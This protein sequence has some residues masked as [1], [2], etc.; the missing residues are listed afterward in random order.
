MPGLLKMVH[1]IDEIL[2]SENDKMMLKDLRNQ[3]VILIGNHP[4]TKEPPIAF[5]VSQMMYSRFHYMAGREVFDWGNGMVGK[6]IQSAG[7]YSVLAGISDRESLKVS[8]E[9][10]AKKGG[11][12]ALFPEGEPTGGENDNLLPFQAGAAQL[13][14]WGY[15]DAKKKDAD[16]EVYILP[17]FVKYRMSGPLIDIRR[18]VDRSLDIMERH[19]RITKTGKTIVHRLLSIGKQMVLAAEKEFG[20]EPQEEWDFDY[21]VGRLRHT[22]LDMVAERAAIDKWN[23]EANSIEKL[24]KL[25]SVFEMVSIGM[26]DPKLNLPDKET[27]FWG[28]E[29]CQRAYDFISIHTEYIKS[30]PTPERIYEWIYRFENEALG[31][32]R[33]RRQR[34]YVRFT[35]PYKMSEIYPEYKKKKRVI[36]EKLT[37][38]LRN[39]IQGLLDKEKALSYLLFEEDYTF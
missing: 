10:I 2:V 5:Q 3:R 28:R 36:L 20:I 17:M 26:D 25:L 24:R 22:I 31:F 9:I 27:A 4:T 23:K 33:Q 21:R 14:F 1:N 34:A 12:L 6:L 38:D 18:D 16:A 32:S 8:R 11:K 29:F 37:T 7:A 13:G 19:Y 30:F 35:R 39:D 15:E